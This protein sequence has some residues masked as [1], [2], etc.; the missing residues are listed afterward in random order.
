MTEVE[1]D[2]TAA[3]PA[4]RDSI[5]L[6]RPRATTNSWRFEAKAI[7][8]ARAR[9]LPDS[10]APY[11]DTCSSA[12]RV[13]VNHTS[14]WPSAACSPAGM[15]CHP[16]VISVI[17]PQL[18][19][20]SGRRGHRPPRRPP[21]RGQG[22]DERLG[23]MGSRPVKPWPMPQFARAIRDFSRLKKGNPSGGRRA[24][25]PVRVFTLENLGNC[26]K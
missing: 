10:D 16:F 18:P 4:T 11:A 22:A 12:S 21:G 24:A 19:Q 20:Q 25:L 1:S 15:V 3:S 5:R 9:S 26:I 17:L 13:E 2:G 8:P 14:I 7:F 23:G 6:S